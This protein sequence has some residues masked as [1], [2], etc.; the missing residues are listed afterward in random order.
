M[1]DAEAIS[2]AL[3]KADFEVIP[4]RD[5]KT[6]TVFSDMTE[7]FENRL[8]RGDVCLIYYA[9][10]LV[11]HDGDNFL[12]P[13]DFDPKDSKGLVDRAY[14]LYLFSEAM[15]RRGVALRIF[16]IEGP[17]SI[18]VDIAGSSN[19]LADPQIKGAG[20]KTQETSFIA[21]ANLNESAP[22]SMVNGVDLFT[23]TAAKAIN[24]QKV[25]LDALFEQVRIDVSAAADRNRR[26]QNPLHLTSVKG[27]FYFHEPEILK[28]RWPRQ[29]VP[30]T[31]NR[32][33]EEY[34]WIDAQTFK[35]GCVPAGEKLCKAAEKPQHEVKLPKG[36]WI[37]R[38]EVK[39]DSFQQYRT[40]IKKKMPKGPM[41]DKKWVHD[42]Y[43]VV[44]VKWED[45]RDYCTWAG[46]KGGAGRLPTEAEWEAAARGGKVDEIYPGN[47]EGSRERA[48]FDGM[49]GNDTFE[50]AA[51]VRK[52]LP[53]PYGLFDMSGNVWEWVN[54]WFGDYPSGAVED[55]KG[56]ATGRKHVI[57]GGS[58]LSDP[59]EHLR[60]SYRDSENSDKANI[61]FRCAIDDTPESRELLPE[62]GKGR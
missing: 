62:P 10:Y 50:F 11:Q 39:V 60:I 52:F 29:D 56:P 49:K 36:F 47:D 23:S 46:G 54:D 21:A 32:D 31:N 16:M 27:T 8:N 18:N 26:P 44:D 12:L 48:N 55:P 42:T 4:M 43:P 1:K 28:P 3:K 45:A 37:G 34:M 6:A 7:K 57:R 13:V 30:V 33:H 53:N 38:N 2:D 51:P 61:G 19:G 41:Y 9:G 14:L 25:P 20:N 24:E 22:A 40:S 17:P 5:F 35:M 59:K 15:E 58:F